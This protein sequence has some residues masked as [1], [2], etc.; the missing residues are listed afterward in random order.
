MKVFLKYQAHK[1][2]SGSLTNMKPVYR[3]LSAGNI[4]IVHL[5]AFL[6]TD[7]CCLTLLTPLRPNIFVAITVS[8]SLYD[9][10][11]SQTV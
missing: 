8:T 7:Y 4:T 6:E 5:P 10:I 11:R 1:T 3:R 2:Y 9:L